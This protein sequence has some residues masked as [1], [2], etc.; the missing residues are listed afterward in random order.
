MD[1]LTFFQGSKFDN[2]TERNIFWRKEKIND[3]YKDVH[4][5]TGDVSL[6]DFLDLQ[7]KGEESDKLVSYL[8]EKGY[9]LDDDTAAAINDQINTQAALQVIQNFYDMYISP[10]GNTDIKYRLG[11]VTGRAIPGTVNGQTDSNGL[12]YTRSLYNAKISYSTWTGKRVEPREEYY[13]VL[14]FPPFK[15][16][17]VKAVSWKKTNDAAA[18]MTMSEYLAESKKERQKELDE[19]NAKLLKEGKEDQI[20]SEEASDTRLIKNAR[21]KEYYDTFDLNALKAARSSFTY[22][23]PGFKAINDN[24]NFLQ[25]MLEGVSGIVS[26]YLTEWDVSLYMQEGLISDSAGQLPNTVYL[27]HRLEEDNPSGY[28]DDRAASWGVINCAVSKVKGDYHRTWDINA[29]PQST[30]H[31]MYP[32]PYTQSGWLNKVTDGDGNTT[33]V[34]VWYDYG[35]EGWTDFLAGKDRNWRRRPDTIQTR[36]MYQDFENAA[37]SGYQDWDYSGQIWKALYTTDDDGFSDVDT[38]F[39]STSAGLYKKSDLISQVEEAV[40]GT[41]SEGEIYDDVT[42]IAG[43]DA[44]GDQQTTGADTQYTDMTGDGDEDDDGKGGY[45]KGGR[46][47]L[48]LFKKKNKKKKEALKKADS[49]QESSSGSSYGAMQD[50]L[51]LVRKSKD[52]DL[53]SVETEDNESYLL[54]VD[55]SMTDNSN[56]VGVPQNNPTLYGGPHGYF[57]SP[58][59]YQSYY[60]ENNGFLRNVPRVD[61]MPDDLSHDSWAGV[62]Y[63]SV[64]NSFDDYYYKGNEKWCSNVG[65]Y[66]Y[67]EHQAYE[68]SWSAGMSHLKEG[69]HTWSWAYAYVKVAEKITVTGSF[70]HR[71]RVS[72]PSYDSNGPIMYTGSTWWYTY[73]PRIVKATKKGYSQ[74]KC[75]KLEQKK[76][77]GNNQMQILTAVPTTSAIRYVWKRTQYKR[78]LLHSE[79]DLNWTIARVQHY[80]SYVASGSSEDLMTAWQK[81]FSKMFGYNKDFLTMYTTGSTEDYELFIPGGGVYS[82]V[83]FYDEKNKQYITDY[84]TGNEHRI[85][86]YMV[87]WNRGVGSHNKLMFLTRNASGLPDCLFRCEVYHSLKPLTYWVQKSKKYS[88]NKRKYWFEPRTG[89]KHYMSVRLHTTDR[90]FAGLYKPSFTSLGSSSESYLDVIDASTVP[91]DGK[92][93]Q[94]IRSS[95]FYSGRAIGSSCVETRKSPYDLMKNN[96]SGRA[97]PRYNP[98][99][100]ADEMT[101]SYT[102]ITGKGIIGDI[103][104]LTFI[105]D[106][107]TPAPQPPQHYLSVFA[108][109]FDKTKTQASY[110]KVDNKVYEVKSRGHTL[111]EVKL[112]GTVNKLGTYD[113]Y[114]SSKACSSL[115]SAINSLKGTGSIVVIV[116]WDACRVDRQLRNCLKEWCGN[117]SNSIWSAQRTSHFL[118]V[119]KNDYWRE[120]ANHNNVSIEGLKFDSKGFISGNERRNT[121]SV[122]ESFSDKMCCL[123]SNKLNLKFKNL[124]FP[125]WRMSY[126]GVAEAS[127]NGNTYRPVGGY[128]V[129]SKTAAPYWWNSMILNMSLRNTFY[130]GDTSGPQK[131][132]FSLLK[133]AIDVTGLSQ[134]AGST[135][136]EK[137]DVTL[138]YEGQ[139]IKITADNISSYTTK[140]RVVYKNNEDNVPV[141]K[142]IS[143]VDTVT[144]KNVWISNKYYFTS[145]DIAPRFM[146]SLVSMQ[147]GFLDSAKKYLCGKDDSGSYYLSFEYIKKI[148]E[149]TSTSASLISP[150]SYMLADPEKTTVTDDDGNMMKCEDVYGYNSFLVDARDMFCNSKEDNDL[151]HQDIEN[152]FNKRINVLSKMRGI[153]APYVNLSMKEYSYNT[154]VTAWKTMDQ[155]INL[156]YDEKIETFLLAYL[157][158]LYE[159]R[160]YFINKRCNKQDGTLWACRHLEKMVPLAISAAVSSSS[161]V[162]L[163]DYSQMS[164][165]Q[166]V[167]FYE[168]QNT[169]ADKANVIKERAKGSSTKSLEDD[170]IVTVYVKVKYATAADY[171][172][173]QKKLR[174]GTISRNDERIIK[175]YP[176]SFVKRSDG[177]FKKRSDGEE[178][179]FGEEWNENDYA[180]RRSKVR[181]AVKPE[182]GVYKLLSKEIKLDERNKQIRLA[183]PDSSVTVYDY[184]TAQWSIDWDS[185]SSKIVYNLYGGVD[186]SKIRDLT[187]AGA[188]DPMT[189]LC[190]AKESTDYWRIPVMTSKPLAEGYKSQITLEKVNTSPSENGENV[191]GKNNE[192]ALTGM[193]AYAMWPIIE[194][195]EDVIPNAGDFADSVRSLIK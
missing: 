145:F 59:S 159:A 98:K 191:D 104:G 7:R 109:N 27:T 38:I 12:M 112:D 129:Y 84:M 76:W 35:K 72:F 40:Y 91:K 9:N 142:T 116:S 50:S 15:P 92:V 95:S 4:R 127:Y 111:F 179:S 51:G 193:S 34:P 130:R 151:I 45:K 63:P 177:T 97:V 162:N 108:T 169:L 144:L 25:W 188:K 153:L 180:I 29:Y 134:A 131:K 11:E 103:P 30:F 107:K 126:F 135:V 17:A 36:L 60:Q 8:N 96:V 21:R 189:I 77:L 124:E 2:N 161:R 73:I 89:W 148:M 19:L 33:L 10:T 118:I 141:P 68:Q 69:I 136:I 165:K 13:S 23:A 128:P 119:R 166:N 106:D 42:I 172:K 100:N 55:E 46:L 163:S 47:F 190:G 157:N 195:Q 16:S 122:V 66:V 85:M 160:R 82:K 137:R 62:S 71:N 138:T 123:Q 14:W 192:I 94:D 3:F 183:N 20:T 57:R 155:F 52:H 139:S 186:V 56:G 121:E 65:A 53:T 6:S 39:L 81:T 64:P 143:V 181:Y 133:F 194:E 173:S 168:V 18:T 185:L 80:Y 156:K 26:T 164:A 58:R 176:W 83:S 79:P 24:I 88:S 174:E 99:T 54:G 171:S 182:N 158:V 93:S 184:E 146:Y 110:L 105:P 175:V 170:R 87:D 32:N 67:G 114:E 152:E 5:T 86:S 70:D 154:M 74:Y 41:S 167:A 49:M 75:K 120:L 90:F 125:M 178:L 115:V 101:S 150:R 61:K 1:F 78:Y 187:A 147:M 22:R 117:S 44:S 102:G 149:G 43:N 31:T 28:K 113:T 37:L 140:D 132:T 48:S